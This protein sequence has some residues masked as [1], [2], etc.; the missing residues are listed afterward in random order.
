MGKPDTL[1]V[2]AADPSKPVFKAGYTRRE[3]DKD[4][5]DIHVIRGEVVE[6]PN[7]IYYR[8][9]LADGDLVVATLEV[10]SAAPA[11]EGEE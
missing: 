9:R 7:N 2:R 8:R 6:V 11:P 5:N 10:A 3:L 1:L 4:G